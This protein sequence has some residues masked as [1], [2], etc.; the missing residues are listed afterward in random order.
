MVKNGDLLVRGGRVVRLDGDR[1]ADLLI[2]AGRVTEVGADLT[3]PPGC[4]VLD[5][6]GCLLLP[7]LIDPQVHFREPGLELV[8]VRSEGRELPRSLIAPDPIRAA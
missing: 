2:E 8:P 7:G 6:T 3:A 4:P 5:A 1:P